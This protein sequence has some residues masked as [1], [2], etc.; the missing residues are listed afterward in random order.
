MALEGIS[1]RVADRVRDLVARSGHRSRRRVSVRSLHENSRR[2]CVSPGL[3]RA[4]FTHADTGRFG[5]SRRH[6]R[7]SDLRAML[8]SFWSHVSGAEETE[9]WRTRI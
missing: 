6:Q 7:L 9:E 2:D 8:C 5:W 4:V 3:E 1:V